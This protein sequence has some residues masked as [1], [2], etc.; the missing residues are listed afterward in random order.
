MADVSLTP[1]QI[2]AGAGI[3]GGLGINRLLVLPGSSWAEN[4]LTF[5]L[6]AAP[7][8]IAVY[9]VTENDSGNV[10]LIE[11]G[12]DFMLT[13]PGQFAVITIGATSLISVMYELF[14][15][16]EVATVAAFL[17]FLQLRNIDLVVVGTGVMASFMFG[18]ILGWPLEVLEWAAVGGNGPPPRKP[19]GRSCWKLQDIPK[20]FFFLVAAQPL[21]LLQALEDFQQHG[22]FIPLF[23]A[24]IHGAAVAWSRVGDIIIDLNALEQ[25][26]DSFVGEAFKLFDDVYKIYK[27]V[28][29]WTPMSMKDSGQI[30]P[31][32]D[33]YPGMYT[34]DGGNPSVYNGGQFMLMPRFFIEG[35]NNALNGTH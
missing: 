4:F 9:Y 8:A 16:P 28:K 30:P 22:N 34:P 25:W 11:S 26:V 35:D 3:L 23:F 12:I 14:L 32:T 7:V 21:A 5:A 31:S 1:D 20:D 10:K 15:M 17:P 6:G 2:A 13:S 18:A 29:H 27:E 33:P 24:P 19:S